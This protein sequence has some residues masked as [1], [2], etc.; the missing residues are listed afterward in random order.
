MDMIEIIISAAM[1]GV[2]F[3]SALLGF[4]ISLIKA[5]KNGRRADGVQAT[6]DIEDLAID[7]ITNVEKIYSQ[8]SKIMK[9]MGVKTGEIKKDNVMNYI[10]SK[11][12]EKGIKFD[13]EY[14]SNQVEELVQLINVNRES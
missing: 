7:K 14:W 1:A 11:C 13:R 2:A 12:A 3:L 10:E 9:N 4:I 8:A 5:I 6:M